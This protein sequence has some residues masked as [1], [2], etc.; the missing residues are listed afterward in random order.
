MK[1]NPDF[2]FLTKNGL[3]N[4]F[5]LDQFLNRL[6]FNKQVTSNNLDLV[7]FIQKDYRLQESLKVNLIDDLLSARSGQEPFFLRPLL[8]LDYS[9]APVLK[10]YLK[11]FFVNENNL[12]ELY[13]KWYLEASLLNKNPGRLSTPSQTALF[14]ATI[15]LFTEGF[16]EKTV[17]LAFL[18]VLKVLD[19]SPGQI[20]FDK[21]SFRDLLK[22]FRDRVYR[23][24]LEFMS[25]YSKNNFKESFQYVNDQFLK[26]TYLRGLQD[27][28]RRVVFIFAFNVFDNKL[29]NEEIV[30]AGREQSTEKEV[31][32]QFQFLINLVNDHDLTN[33]FNNLINS[34][35]LGQVEDYKLMLTINN[36]SDQLAAVIINQENILKANNLLKPTKVLVSNL[37]YALFDKRDVEKLP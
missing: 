5:K 26:K 33:D 17:D 37:N 24:S 18:D 29:S 7:S 30:K 27:G 28:V 36:F 20:G 4:D 19:P 22:A 12:D 8:S 9:Q 23:G 32:D 11:D 16:V 15:E 31:F 13:S 25:N 2:F 35:H 14:Q 3:L 6:Y 10:K 21:D 1:D 34:K